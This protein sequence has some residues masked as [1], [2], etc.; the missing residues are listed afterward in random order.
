MLGGSSA[1]ARLTGCAP[2]SVTEWRRRGIPATRCAQL[3]R[4]TR[5]EVACELLNPSLS[6]VRVADPEWPWHP[7][8]RPL[9]DVTKSA[10]AQATAATPTEVRHAA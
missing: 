2:A 10:E 9:I 4:A 5:G 8:G 1:V 3:E 6:W 7:A